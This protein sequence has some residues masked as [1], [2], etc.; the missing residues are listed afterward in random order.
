MEKYLDATLSPEE[1]AQDLLSKLS[2]EEKMGQVIGSYAFPFEMLP[3]GT[4]DRMKYAMP[5]GVGQLSA[6]F[7]RTRR[8]VHE[9]LELQRKWQEIVME[10]SPHHIP[11]I[12]HMEGLTGSMMIGATSFPANI[13]RGASFDPA[14]EEK[15]GQITAR[16]ELPGGMTQILCPVLDVNRDPRLGRIGETYGEDPT[17]AAA[18]GAAMTKG[19]QETEVGGLHADACAKHFMGFHS[20]EGG[21]HGSGTY[22]GDRQLLETYGKS[23]QAA[24]AL[25]DL[26]AVMPCYDSMDGVPASASHHLLTEL[27]RDE[28]GFNGAAISD[29]GAVA[30]IHNV[31]GV[32]E[33]L[34]EAGYLSMKAGM[35]CELPM[36]EAYNKELKAMFE[37]GRADMAVLDQAVLRELTAKFRMGLFEHPF[38]LPD[39]EFDKIFYDE[40]DRAVSLQ[41]ARESLILLKNDGTLPLKKGLKK[42]A[43]IGPHADWANHYFGGYTQFTFVEGMYAAQSSMAGVMGN[44]GASEVKRIPGTRVEFSET[45]KFREIMDWAKPGVDTILKK[46]R[47]DLPD[48]EITYAHGYQVAGADESE[49][50]EA[51][52]ACEGA[53]LI[54]LTLGGKHGTSSIATMGEGVDGT[55]INLPRCQDRFIEEAAKLGIPM[56]GVHLDGRPISSDIADEKLSAIL[57]CFSPS[58]CTAEAVSEVLRGVVNPSGKLPVS[59]AYTA[60]QIPVYYNH[61]N[62]SAWHQGMSI[63]FQNYIDCPHTPR[64]FFGHGL[65][66][67]TFEYSG[68]SVN[69]TPQQQEEE[70]GGIEKVLK[71]AQ[72]GQN[73]GGTRAGY[74]ASDIKEYEPETIPEVRPDG[75]IRISFT[76]KNTGDCEGTEV[77]QLY[78]RDK[79]AS[80]TRPVQELQ[81]FRR[82][83]L[84]P[85]ASKK[86][87]FTVD[88]SQMAFLTTDMRWKVEK[89]RFDVLIGSSSADI[90]LT[91]AYA[92]TEDAYIKGKER[93]FFAE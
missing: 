87:D 19:L 42:I 93:S 77:V 91:G 85:G 13:N 44:D 71:K 35:D 78:L 1:R 41:S 80:M 26:H 7:M 57:E 2:L 70:L 8:D 51:L 55:N 4:L 21:I 3:E 39:E 66:Y 63:G 16:Q 53:D 11:A 86:V 23:F 67:T 17:L 58:E 38:A 75:K 46:L 76:L 68:L 30:N 14:L 56:V 18:M 48:A 64:Y 72:F 32:S 79:F 82:V 92:V 52:Q 34:E 27:L 43:L 24:I 36:Q 73:L 40:K 83:T 28:M 5:G 25:S 49:F 84:A 45:D 89:G 6:L 59:V 9:V 69:G 61:P 81:G 62:G 29:Y 74:E 60:G 47:E 20:S 37:D 33:T 15:I 22:I 88:P 65:S 10:L 90:R 12:F 31:Q 54:I 50:S